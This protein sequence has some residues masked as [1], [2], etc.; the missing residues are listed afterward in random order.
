[1]SLVMWP[2]S[3]VDTWVS[4]MIGAFL[5]VSSAA[6]VSSSPFFGVAVVVR[7]LSLSPFLAGSFVYLA[8]PPTAPLVL[9]G[10]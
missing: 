1:M 6:A 4:N 3:A 2:C 9:F 7:R 10:H 5:D 8:A